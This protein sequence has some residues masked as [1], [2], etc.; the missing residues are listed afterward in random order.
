MKYT[1]PYYG[2]KM[3]A[4]EADAAYDGCPSC[5]KRIEWDSYLT[6]PEIGELEHLAEEERWQREAD[7]R[8]VRDRRRKRNF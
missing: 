1:C 5:R 3:T 4:L 2:H 6:G 7:R 8:A